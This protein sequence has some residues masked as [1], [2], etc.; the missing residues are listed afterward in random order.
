MTS[1][2]FQHALDLL[3]LHPKD[4]AAWIDCDERMVRRWAVGKMLIPSRVADWLEGLVTYLEQHPR[5]QL[6]SG[7]T[8]IQQ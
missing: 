3:G 7:K 2:Q 1:A 4:F 8:E 5:P 6:R